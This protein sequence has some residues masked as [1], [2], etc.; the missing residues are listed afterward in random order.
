M[1]F[2]KMSKISKIVLPCSGNSI[3][4]RTTRMPQSQ[5]HNRDFSRL[6]S[7]SLAGKCFSRKKDL[8]Y[9]SKFWNFMLFTAQVGDLFMGGRSNHERY[10]E[11]FATQ[12]AISREWNFQSRKTLRKF[13]QKFS[14]KC[15]GGYPWRLERNLFQ[16]RKSRVLHKMGQ[17]LNFSVFPQTF[18]TVHLLPYLKHSQTHCLTLKQTS[19]FESFHSQIFKEKGM[20]FYFLTLFYIF[21]WVFPHFVRFFLSLCVLHCSNMGLLQILVLVV[22]G[23]LFLLLDC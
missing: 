7:N 12:F 1:F 4:G 8:E 5:V 17:F 13:F 11:I 18:L 6:T 20:S 19:I 2:A 3:A 10:T 21:I 15:S 9:F 22:W 23:W 16:S 14:S